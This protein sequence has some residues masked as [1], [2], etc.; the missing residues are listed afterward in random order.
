MFQK[1]K[2]TYSMLILIVW[3]LSSCNNDRNVKIHT[4]VDKT[5]LLRIAQFAD[6]LSL[7]TS[8]SLSQHFNSKSCAE[9]NQCDFKLYRHTYKLKKSISIIIFKINRYFIMKG[10]GHDEDLLPLYSL[11]PTIKKIFDE[12]IYMQTLKEMSDQ[13]IQIMTASSTKTFVLQ[14]KD[15]SRDKELVDLLKICFK[16]K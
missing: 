11:S 10:W 14:D 16:K 2:L 8:K 6:T 3:M 15:L 13:E 4:V 12:D 9:L 1:N 5:C 7:D